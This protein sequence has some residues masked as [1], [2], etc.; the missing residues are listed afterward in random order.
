MNNSDAYTYYFPITVRY[1]DLDPQEHV[2]NA[3]YLSYLESARLGYYQAV[4]IWDAE[5]RVKTGMVVARI[6]I[7][8]LAPIT[9]GQSIQVGL[10]LE[11]MGNKSLTFAF[12]IESVSK[13]KALARGTSVMVAYDNQTQRSVPISKNWRKKFNL[14][15]GWEN[16]DDIT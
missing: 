2:N 13:G 14:F 4:G 1:S 12:L 9:L 7:D 15:E 5:K 16:Q 11:R 8:Y 3:V 10:R 6:E